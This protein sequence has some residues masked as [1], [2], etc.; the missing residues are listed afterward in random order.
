[1]SCPCAASNGPVHT[2]LTTSL[3]RTHQE[4][5]ASCWRFTKRWVSQDFPVPAWPRMK[6][7]T[8]LCCVWSGICILKVKPGAGSAPFLSL[9][10]LRVLLRHVRA[11]D[12]TTGPEGP[13]AC[14]PVLNGLAVDQKVMLADNQKARPAY[15]MVPLVERPD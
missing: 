7:A 13:V 14:L 8:T 2:S 12:A 6:R 11:T 3:S 10:P 1:G 4:R 9:Y 5:P 15:G